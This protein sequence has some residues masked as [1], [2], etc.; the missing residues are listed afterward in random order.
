MTSSASLASDSGE[1]RL[2]LHFFFL[3]LL[4]L[5]LFSF[6]C[7]ERAKRHDIGSRCTLEML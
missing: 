5:L 7:D 3:L 1:M 4:L 2:V 6:N